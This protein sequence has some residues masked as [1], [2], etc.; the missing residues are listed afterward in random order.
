MRRL[1]RGHI[2]G[3]LVPLNPVSS[4][5]PMNKIT[6]QYFNTLTIEQRKALLRS[7]GHFIKEVNT[8]KKSACLYDIA[9]LSVFGTYNSK[10]ELIDL[11]A[12]TTPLPSSLV[13]LQPLQK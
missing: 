4:P 5:S 3:H 11:T 7:K 2:G 1:K 13:S 6:P 8:G 10:S 9:G 12:I